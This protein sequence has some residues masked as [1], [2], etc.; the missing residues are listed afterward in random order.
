MG[1]SPP[2]M[3]RS[4]H[5][6][7]LS[8]QV[9]E[10][11]SRQAQDLGMKALVAVNKSVLAKSSAQDDT[12]TPDAPRQRMTFGVYFYSEPSET[13]PPDTVDPARNSP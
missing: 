5:Y 10:K 9:V 13:P 1:V 3:E 7:M 12:V 11:L 4:V 2:F 8:P 6:D